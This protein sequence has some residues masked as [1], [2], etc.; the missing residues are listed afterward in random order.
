M[1]S[2]YRQLGGKP[3]GIRIDSPRKKMI[4]EGDFAKAELTYLLAGAMHRTTSV[5]LSV[6]PPVCAIPTYRPTHCLG[7]RGPFPGAPLPPGPAGSAVPAGDCSSSSWRS[8][9]RACH[10]NKHAENSKPIYAFASGIPRSSM[11]PLIGPFTCQYSPFVN[12]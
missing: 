9:I 11:P 7:G 4:R 3:T 2:C 6:R 12:D 10:V 8:G 5:C 1:S